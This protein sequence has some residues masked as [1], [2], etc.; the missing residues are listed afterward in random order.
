MTEAVYPCQLFRQRPD[1]PVQA[2]FVATSAD[3]DDWS[4]VPIKTSEELRNFQRPEIPAHINE[5][6]QF[7]ANHDKNCSPS[8]I[9]VGFKSPINCYELIDGEEC[10]IDLE[11][12]QVGTVTNATIKISYNDKE[13]ASDINEKI[14]LLRTLINNYIELNTPPPEESD[15]AVVP[16]IEE[17]LV[18]PPLPQDGEVRL[19]ISAEGSSEEVGDS[20]G[21]KE[22]SSSDFLNTLSQLLTQLS[23][24]SEEEL[25]DWIQNIYDLGKPGLII[26]GQHRTKGTRNSKIYFSVT[27]LPD[28]NWPELAFQFIVLNKS[29]SKVEESLLINIVGNSMSKEELGTISKRLI[30]S[31]VPVGLYQAVMR[32]HEDPTSPF[33]E[34]LKFGIQGEAGIIEAAAAKSKIVSFWYKCAIYPL[35]QHL[36]SG[37]T[38]KEKI[39]HYQTDAWFE[40]LVA[41]WGSAKKAYETSTLWGNDIDTNGVP[42]SKLMQSTIINLT[43]QAILQVYL[44]AKLNE[45]NN[46]VTQTKTM[47]TLIPDLNAFETA[48]DFYFRRLLPEFFSDWNPAA[49]G[50]DGSAA[51]RDYYVKA[52]TLV[53]SGDKTIT[54]LKQEPHWLFDRM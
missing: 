40:F 16:E 7:F 38:K 11:T 43:Q 31:K 19:E 32:L 47:A 37:K 53:V 26:D 21:D 17:P 54:Q 30:D 15:L 24:L 9:V 41:F 12:I 45:I 34:K 51:V 14:S 1:S 35:I 49:T 33:R 50:L 13:S 18:I 28:A 20:D 44:N 8:S 25:D 39:L 36:L 10:L 3:I 29:A 48:S 6:Y 2:V 42:A 22:T 27:A 5:I 4:S 23:N 46:D 52:V